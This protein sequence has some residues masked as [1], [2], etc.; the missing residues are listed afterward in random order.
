MQAFKFATEIDMKTL[1]FRK[2]KDMLNPRHTFGACRHLNYVYAIG[3][4]GG[5]YRLSGA[6][7]RFNLTT[8]VWEELPS[9]PIK[10]ERTQAFALG[11]WIYTVGGAAM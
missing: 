7:E 10:L 8:E 6:S 9:T 2:L 11:E 5:S 1:Q 3:G 4:N